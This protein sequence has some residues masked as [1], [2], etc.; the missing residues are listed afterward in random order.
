[1]DKLKHIQSGD[2]VTFLHH[3]EQVRAIVTGWCDRWYDGRWK[4]CVMLSR[5]A[6]IPVDEVVSRTRRQGSDAGIIM[7]EQPL[8]S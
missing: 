4:K 6:S 7:F 1:M 5:H 3:G 8:A 2:E